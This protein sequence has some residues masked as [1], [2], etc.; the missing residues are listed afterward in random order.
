MGIY[1]YSIWHQASPTTQGFYISAL[2][3]KKLKQGITLVLIGYDTQI[4]PEQCC[5]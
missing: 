1:A 3:A 4:R 5:L 2:D